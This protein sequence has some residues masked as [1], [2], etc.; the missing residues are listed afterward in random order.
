MFYTGTLASVTAW[1]GGDSTLEIG[2]GGTT[3][4]TQYGALVATTLVSL[5]G[6]LQVFDFNGFSPAV[7]N[8]FDILDWP[9]NERVGTF[10]SV[11]LPPL[12]ADRAWDTSQL[13][14]TGVISVVA[15][16]LAGD[17]NHNGVVDAAD[18]VVWRNGLGTVYT[19]ADYSVWR[20]HFGQTAGSGSGA[21]GFASAIPEPSAF[22]L[23]AVG[24]LGLSGCRR[25]GHDHFFSGRMFCALGVRSGSSVSGSVTDHSLIPIQSVRT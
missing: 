19:Q 21:T 14:T 12:A 13:Y 2:L 20:T 11:L 9:T 8:S 4:N 10:S 7:G 18:Y 5:S 17:Y 3:R 15:S 23:T 24:F 22:V 1:L 25:A 16:G 6:T